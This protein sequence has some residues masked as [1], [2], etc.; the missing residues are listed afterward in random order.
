[1]QG[2]TARRVNLSGAFLVERED[3][4]RIASGGEGKTESLL[5]SGISL[6]GVLGGLKGVEGRMNL[7][8]LA[9][10]TKLAQQKGFQHGLEVASPLVGLLAAADDNDD[11]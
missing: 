10:H 4:L 11:C 9:C 5:S 3:L 7:A 2:E 8:K 1:L 6:C